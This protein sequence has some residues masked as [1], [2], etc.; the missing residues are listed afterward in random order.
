MARVNGINSDTDDNNVVWLRE[1]QQ[2]VIFLSTVNLDEPQSVEA[3]TLV[4]SPN[5][6]VDVEDAG[7]LAATSFRNFV[8]SPEG[9]EIFGYVLDGA[10]G[11][12]RA[13]LDQTVMDQVVN[14][15]RD[16]NFT[17]PQYPDFEPPMF[18][19]AAQVG[20]DAE[21]ISIFDQGQSALV[22]F[23]EGQAPE[24]LMSNQ[25]G[26]R[27]MMIVAQ[28][29]YAD[30]VV[31]YADDLGLPLT[32]GDV[33]ARLTASLNLGDSIAPELNDGPPAKIEVV[34]DGARISG[35]PR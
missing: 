8:S 22:I 2:D 32:E 33:A 12:E 4:A 28:Q 1:Y 27:D 15:L 35:L 3:A 25:T 19:L 23:P 17:D 24:V 7:R 34:Y 6:V 5:D 21:G 26:F 9:A 11:G 18:R 16:P 30:V 14:S 10:F 31:A 20:L 29:A 13:Q